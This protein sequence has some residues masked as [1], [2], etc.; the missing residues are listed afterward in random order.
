[1]K[2]KGN[3]NQEGWVC[4]HPS[5][6]AE[7][8][9]LLLDLGDPSLGLWSP[10]KKLAAPR[11]PSL[12]LWQQQLSWLLVSKC[13]GW[14]YTSVSACICRK[15]DIRR[16][17]RWRPSKAVRKKGCSLP[18]LSVWGVSNLG[19]LWLVDEL[20]PFLPPC[21]CGLTSVSVSNFPSS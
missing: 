1:M 12:W 11:F 19:V 21:S 14:W 9:L 18:L 2:R 10:G 17:T 8:H 7:I 16:L 5:F 3:G 13:V 6:S 4:P 20:L 15:S